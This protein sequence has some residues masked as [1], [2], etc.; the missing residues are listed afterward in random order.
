MHSSFALRFPFGHHDN[1]QILK[2]IDAIRGRTRHHSDAPAMSCKKL[3]DLDTPVVRVRPS[4]PAPRIIRCRENFRKRLLGERHVPYQPDTISRLERRSNP[5]DYRR[6]GVLC[7]Y[8]CLKQ[9]VAMHCVVFQWRKCCPRR[10]AFV[11]AFKRR[12]T[13]PWMDDH[14]VACTHLAGKT[15]GDE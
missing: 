3:S 11:I 15:G 1:G 9:V 10:S 7:L 8:L 14:K 4:V 2:S 13:M 5:V 6:D 12:A